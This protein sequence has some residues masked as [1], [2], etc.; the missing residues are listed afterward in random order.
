MPRSKASE[1]QVPATQTSS[2]PTSPAKVVRPQVSGSGDVGLG[3]PPASRSSAGQGQLDGSSDSHGSKADGRSNFRGDLEGLRAV[4]VILVL[5]YHAQI[6]GFPG[7]YVGVDVFFVLSGFLITG[8]L[9][10]ERQSSGAISLPGFYARRARRILPAGMLVLMVTLV[11][12]ALFLPPLSVPDTARD[13]A[14]AALYISNIRFGIQATDYLASQQAASPI[15]HYWSL[16]VEEQF[17]VF[18]PAIVLL[19]CRGG[20]SIG[21]RIGITALVISLASVLLS[22]WLT[23]ANAPWAFF[24]LPTRAWELGIGAMLAVS[25]SWLMR[26][27]ARLAAALGWAGLAS[28]AL[29]GVV[30]NDAT[31]FPGTA[32]LLPTVGAALVIVAGFRPPHALAPAR[33]LG[34]AIPRYIGRISYSL[35]LW[36]WPLLVIPAAAAGAPLPMQERVALVGV[37]VVLSAMSQRFIEDPIR[38]G[39]FVGTRPSRNLAMAGALSLTVTVCALGLAMTAVAPSLAA[40]TQSAVAS[41]EATVNQIIDAALAAT[42]GGATMADLP[43]TI[44]RPVPAALTPSLADARDDLPAPYVDGCHVGTDGVTSAACRYGDLNGSHTVVLFGDSHA[45]EWWPALE[46]L[47]LQS[48]WR[49]VSYT[50]SAC[51]PGDVAQWEASLKRVYTECQVWR[52]DT[53]SRIASLDPDLVVVSGTTP[54]PLVRP[55]G[56]LYTDAE[57]PAVYTAGLARTLETLSQSAAHVVMLGNTPLSKFDVPVCLSAHANSILACSTPVAQAFSPTWHEA[58][59]QAAKNAGATYVDPTSWICSSS[60][61]PPVVGNFLVYRDDQHLTPPFSEA[62]AARLAMTLPGFP[63]GDAPGGGSGPAPSRTPSLPPTAYGETPPTAPTG[64]GLR[65]A[66]IRT[67]RRP[68]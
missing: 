23:D 21:R 12:S 37:A 52:E 24:S 11:L 4:A 22:V 68:L 15:L 1:G 20:G 58:T 41:D 29:A 48:G 45:L 14:A 3:G 66:S 57:G 13:A 46:R 33:L 40:T 16:G 49:F 2:K 47:A 63:Q 50:K 59:K 18:W 8:I 44:D 10:R 9:L 36:H 54:S 42:S 35:Y 28:V 6:P 65:T 39:R 60:P 51:S 7:G 27:P 55:D 43:R 64:D 25:G 32:A 38:H 5:L 34:T 19:V 61:C 62:L 31:P 53:L 67:R 30:F 17:Y 26:I 56:T